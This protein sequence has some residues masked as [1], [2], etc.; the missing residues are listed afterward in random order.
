MF[1]ESLKIDW[2]RGANDNRLVNDNKRSTEYQIPLSPLKNKLQRQSYALCPQ[3]HPHKA[4]DLGKGRSAHCL[5]GV[6]LYR[7]RREHMLGM[8][9]EERSFK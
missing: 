5:A 6:G 7:C 9:G 2:M 3:N 8:N 4:K 1:Y